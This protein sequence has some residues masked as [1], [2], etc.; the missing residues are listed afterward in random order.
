MRG[1]HSTLVRVASRT[2]TTATTLM[3]ALGREDDACS[4]TRYCS[5]FFVFF[6]DGSEW[7]EK[8]GEI[9]REEGEGGREREGESE[10][11]REGEGETEI[12]RERQT[13]RDRERE[14]ETERERERERE[15]ERERETNRERERIS[16]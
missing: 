9:E 6:A 5:C 1:R 3:T 11:E 14:R 4:H 12:E 15:N 7:G 16:C 8:K 13:E 2:G 10:G